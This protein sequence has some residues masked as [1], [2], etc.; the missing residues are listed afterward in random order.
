[1]SVV[2]PSTN[3]V[4][5]DGLYVLTAEVNKYDYLPE[6]N[7][8][9]KNNLGKLPFRITGGVA[10]IDQAAMLVNKP[11]PVTNVTSSVNF[12]GRYKTVT[13]TWEGSAGWYC[14]VSGGQILY[15]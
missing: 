6:Y 4:P 5:D 1:N 14:V 12:K 9:K 7:N 11:Q 2:I 10:T 8:N 3:L 13:L 15:E